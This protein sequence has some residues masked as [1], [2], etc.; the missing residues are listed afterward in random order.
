[1]NNKVF[2]WQL[3]NIKMNLSSEKNGENDF[4]YVNNNMQL[5]WSLL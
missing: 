1:M 2:W 5:F 4:V 3:S